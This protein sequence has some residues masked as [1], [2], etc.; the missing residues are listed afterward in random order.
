MTRVNPYSLERFLC[1]SAQLL[2]NNEPLHLFTS[3]ITVKIIAKDI[4]HHYYGTNVTQ[5][6]STKFPVS[7]VVMIHYTWHGGKTRNGEAR[8]R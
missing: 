8:D 1:F 7:A 4:I 2:N 5:G 6:N 3:K